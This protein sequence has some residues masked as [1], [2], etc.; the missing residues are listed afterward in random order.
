MRNTNGTKAKNRTNVA[1]HGLK[2]SR[3]PSEHLQGLA[4]PSKT[5][6]L[7]TAR[8]GSTLWDCWLGY[9]LS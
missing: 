8:N 5:T 1:K 9:W 6:V 7:I 4:S 2:L 3:M